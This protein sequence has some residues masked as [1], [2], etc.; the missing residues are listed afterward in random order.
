[1]PTR[2]ATLIGKYYSGSDLRYYF[3]GQLFSNYNATGGF[4]PTN[5]NA[6]STATS[7]FASALSIDG[8]STVL[9]GV[10]AAGA[11]VVIPQLPVRAKGG[12]TQLGLP[13]PAGSVTTPKA[14]TLA[15][16]ST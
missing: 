4:T 3:A 9:F 6:T 5:L 14:A 7:V 10:N 16:L 2:F 1:L 15:G 13:F 11:P 8:A 12:F